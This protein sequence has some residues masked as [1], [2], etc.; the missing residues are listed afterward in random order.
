MELTKNYKQAQKRL[1]QIQENMTSNSLEAANLRENIIQIHKDRLIEINDLY[2]HDRWV[3]LYPHD[4]ISCIKLS[5]EI[6][7]ETDKRI[8]YD[9]HFEMVAPPD[10]NL[11]MRGRSSLGEKVFASIIVR[12]ALADIFAKDCPIFGLDAP[13]GNLDDSINEKLID[14]LAE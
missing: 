2:L 6:K 10:V 4:D 7:N 3:Q 11:K 12:H 14:L 13:D 1:S 9:Y 8:D 5:A